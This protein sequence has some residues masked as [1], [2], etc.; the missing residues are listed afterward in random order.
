M[1]KNLLPI[2]IFLLVFGCM[3]SG[4]DRLPQE[5]QEAAAVLKNSYQ[6]AQLYNDSLILA[7]NGSISND[8]IRVH[9]FDSRY[10]FYDFKFDSCHYAYLHN[11]NS[12]NHSHNGNALQMHGTGNGMMGDCNCCGNGG[13]DAGLHQQ[14]ADL[15]ILHEL[16]H[17]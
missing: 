15:H 4:N 11:L 14:M 16:Y 17:P 12:A 8:Y 6:N 7:R 13:H 9:Y 2:L 5:Q 3:K 1:K 10:H